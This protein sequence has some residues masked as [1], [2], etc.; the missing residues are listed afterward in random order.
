M[1][2][3]T[4]LPANICRWGVVLLGTLGATLACGG[5]QVGPLPPE[6]TFYL[7]SPGEDGASSA[8]AV[9]ASD[10]AAYDVLVERIGTYNGFLADRIPLLR[11]LQQQTARQLDRAG[12][13]EFVAA[14]ERATVTLRAVEDEAGAVVYSVTVSVEGGDP[15]TLLEGDADAER[16]SGTWRI[17]RDG[18]V[19]VDV[20]W[21]TANPGGESL[22]VDRTVRAAAGER[23]SRFALTADAVTLTF[24]GPNHDATAEWDRA[25]GDGQ[26]TVDDTTQCFATSEDGADVCTVACAS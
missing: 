2:R 21:T 26:I 19:V 20:A 23:S 18:E 12:E 22:V 16:S 25:T 3:V 4:S 10:T 7:P 11:A 8:Q 9:C 15:I 1:Q 17:L 13:V 14:G 5:R 6:E 24:V